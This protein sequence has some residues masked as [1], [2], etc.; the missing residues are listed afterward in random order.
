MILV[1]LKG[2]LGNQMFQYAF[3][4]S[5]QS[6]TNAAVKLEM[7]S[8]L[9]RNKGDFVYRDYDLPIF[10]VKLPLHTSHSVLKKISDLK[11]SRLTRLVQKI[12]L[13]KFNVIVEPHFHH[14]KDI[15]KPNDN[16]LYDGWWQSH[17]YFEGIET[18]L[19]KDFSFSNAV[20]ENSFQIKRKIQESNA[21]CL[22]VRRTDFLQNDV[23][24]STDLNYFIRGVD[25]VKNHVEDPHFF[26]F[27]DDIEWCKEYIK[28]HAPMT[29]VDH[30]HKGY[31]FGNYLQL[32]SM[33]DHFIIP[34]SSFAYWAVWLRNNHEGIVV[35]PKNWFANEEY[36]TTDLV[37]DSWYRC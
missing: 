14:S 1:R 16:G 37:R 35:A 18:A 17:L 15:M 12:R 26:V 11:V 31:K 8:L 32:M 19:R 3:A 9:N 4:K 28:P 24:N 36:I 10:N 25:Y 23:L 29:V 34:N 2:G 6:R 13:K 5:L 33:C 7:H 30:S 22:N 20:E 21:V 27:S